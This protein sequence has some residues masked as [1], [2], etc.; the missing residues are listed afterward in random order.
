MGSSVQEPARGARGR[1]TLQIIADAL[2]VSTATV[3]LALRNAPVVAEATRLRVH[4]AARDL[5]YTYNRGAAALRTARSDMLAV[6][7]SDVALP[8]HAAILGAVEDTARAAGRTILLGTTAEDLVRQEQV[9]AM[10]REFRP[11]GLLI[12]PAAGTKAAALY[13]LVAAGIPVVQVAREV[14]G[15]AF[16]YVGS[17]ETLAACLAVEHLLALGHR[18]IGMIGG[19]EGVSSHRDRRRAFCEALQRAGVPVDCGWLLDGYGSRE[20]GIA[21]MGRLLALK[22]APTAVVCVDDL[23][24]IGAMI[25]LARADLRPGR[26]LSVVG[27]GDAPEAVAF[28]PQLSTVR[29]H[30][31]AIGRRAAEVLMRRIAEPEAPPERHVIPPELVVRASCARLERIAA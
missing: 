11:D 6:A 12:A 14:D 29:A 8:D 3:S 21:G 17:D 2:G 31:A 27:C 23:T 15:L 25:G 24:A 13:H 7:L 22:E 16:D 20:T 26:D 4:Q 28:E 1:V 9:L 19:A 30:H 5:G 10:L 18:R